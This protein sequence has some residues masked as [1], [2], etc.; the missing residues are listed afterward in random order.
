MIKLSRGPKPS[1]LERNAATWTAEFTAHVGPLSTMSATTRYRYRASEIKTAVKRDSHS[2]CIYCESCVS[3]VHPGEIEHILP[4]SK[5]RDLV[6]DWDNLAFVCTECN[7]EKSDYLEPELP[8]VNP[9]VDEPKEYLAFYG[10]IIH[11]R[12]GSARGEITVRRLRLSDR[13]D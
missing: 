5:R 9:Y 1:I 8:L 11:H 4:A 12:T 13:S 6:V 2:K 10:P 7:R 3:Q